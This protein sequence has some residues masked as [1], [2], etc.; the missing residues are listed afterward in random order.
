MSMFTEEQ[1]R[2]PWAWCRQVIERHGITSR[3][4]AEKTGAPWS[5]TRAL[6]NG[7]TNAP[8]YDLLTRIIGVCISYENVVE[9]ADELDFM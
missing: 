3:D 8:R 2:D 4:L 1:F 5:T 9:L 7:T 6:L